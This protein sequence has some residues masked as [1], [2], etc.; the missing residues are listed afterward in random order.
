MNFYATELGSIEWTPK[1]VDPEK[2]RLA[3]WQMQFTTLDNGIDRV[4]GQIIS[5]ARHA[6]EKQH[7]RIA[8]LE[9]TVAALNADATR[10]RWIR[11]KDNFPMDE[12]EGDSVWDFLCDLECSE[13]DS[14]IDEVINNTKEAT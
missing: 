4:P 7:R 8:E 11:D 13:F 5:A 2:V 1:S 12:G 6:I 10:Y 14:F 9:Q 3:L